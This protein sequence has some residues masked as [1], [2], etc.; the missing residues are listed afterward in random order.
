MFRANVRD[1]PL[2]VRVLALC[3]GSVNACDGL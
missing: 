1:G 2:E 3:E